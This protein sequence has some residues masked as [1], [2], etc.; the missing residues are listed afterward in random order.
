V[1]KVRVVQVDAAREKMLL[2]LDTSAK[3]AESSA[4]AGEGKGQGKA[5]ELQPAT[6]LTSCVVVAVAADGLTVEFD[7]RRKGF[8]PAEHLSDHPEMCAELLNALQPGAKLK[9]RLGV[10]LAPKAPGKRGF[11][12]GSAAGGRGLM[13]A[14]VGLVQTRAGAARGVE[15]AA[16]DGG[17]ARA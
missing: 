16:V 12:S 10:L 6:V 2:S 17:D 4:A 1:L 9:P 14:G 15:R 5:A 11:V 7:G 8:C 3:A 13:R